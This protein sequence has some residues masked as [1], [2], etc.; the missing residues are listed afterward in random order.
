MDL[1]KKGRKNFTIHNNKHTSA[2]VTDR[3]AVKLAA[4]ARETQNKNIIAVPVTIKKVFFS[5]N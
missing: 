3:F 2:L 1:K 4:G 5:I